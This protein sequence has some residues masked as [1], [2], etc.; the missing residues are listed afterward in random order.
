MNDISILLNCNLGG[1]I[2]GQLLNHLIYADDV[3]LISF[4][5][6]TKYF[7]GWKIAVGHSQ[8][9]LLHE[10]YSV[11]VFPSTHP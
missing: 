3:C 6:C 1:K 7:A 8:E 10:K 4:N 9:S 5:I 11:H 2:G